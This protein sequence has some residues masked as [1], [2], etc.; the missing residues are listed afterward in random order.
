MTDQLDPVL[1]HAEGATKAS[2]QRLIDFLSIPSVGTDP[3]HKQDVAAAAEWVAQQLRDVGLQPQIVAAG[4]HPSVI[5]R[6]TDADVADPGAHPGAGAPR[7]LFY[8]HHDV[9]PADPLELWTSGPFE[10]VVRN[11][12]V[13][14]RGS[15]DDKGQ[16]LCFLEALRAWRAVGNGKLPCHVT[17]LI[18]GEEEIG[19]PTLEQIIHDHRS[20]LDDADIAVISDTTM[21][22]TSEG[23]NLPAITYGMRGL[24]YLDLELHGPSRDLHSGVYGGSLANPATMLARVLGQLWDDDNR[25][26]VPGIYDDVDPLTPEEA[27]AWEQL[28]FRDADFLGAIGVEPFGEANCDTLTRRWA[29]PALDVNG[30]RG[31]FQGH[32]AKTVI[33]SSAGAKLSMRIPPSMDPHKTADALVAWLESQDVGGCR[34]QITRHGEAW[35]VK[36]PLDSPWM[37]AATSAI[38]RVAGRPPVLVRDGATIPVVADM[39]RIL[40]LDT[41]LIGFGLHSDQIHSPD[42][43]FGLDRFALG[44]QTHAAVLQAV[45]QAEA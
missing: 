28:G 6:T 21:W 14:A 27:R 31:G 33:A 12:A 41:L 13:Y 15:S 18:E 30:L 39:K 16:V 5:A 11:G 26:T 8:G 29:R 10:P 44:I 43:H 34:W 20:L 19:S 45:A 1:T 3:A 35:P 32:G 37:A 23:E 17:V 2:Q 40:D 7:V 25:I 42:E 22:T 24:V 38:R 9:Q 4:G 36:V